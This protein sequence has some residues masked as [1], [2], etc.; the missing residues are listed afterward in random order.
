MPP[1]VLCAGLVIVSLVAGVSC[2]V[3]L[4]ELEEAL[5]E[6]ND[7]DSVGERDPG[8]N[9]GKVDLGLGCVV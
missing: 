4:I 6:K 5:K 2:G 7:K 9:L 8:D 1:S 3:I